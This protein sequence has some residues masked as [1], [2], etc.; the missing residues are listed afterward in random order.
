ML[1]IK[2]LSPPSLPLMG[3][4]GHMGG[5]YTRMMCPIVPS[6]PAPELIMPLL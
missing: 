5:V 2:L 1:I 3:Q 6:L 4:M